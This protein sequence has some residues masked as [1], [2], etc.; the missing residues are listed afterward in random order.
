[1][2]RSSS[3]PRAS[4]SSRGGAAGEGVLLRTFHQGLQDVAVTRR[5]RVA[6]AARR[7]ERCGQGMLA[8]VGASEADGSAACNSL[9]ARAR[10]SGV[11]LS[12]LPWRDLERVLESDVCLM[13]Y[14]LGAPALWD[15]ELQRRL[16]HCLA[17]GGLATLTR[18]P[19]T[20]G[21]PTPDR[22]HLCGGG[23]LVSCGTVE[24]AASLAALLGCGQNRAKRSGMRLWLYNFADAESAAA[25]LAFHPAFGATEPGVRVVAAVSRT[26]RACRSV[27]GNEKG[28]EG[29]CGGGCWRVLVASHWVGSPPSSSPPLGVGLPQALVPT[30][31]EQLLERA[32]M[33]LAAAGL[34]KQDQAERKHNGES[35]EGEGGFGALLPELLEAFM[36]AASV[37]SDKPLSQLCDD[38]VVESLQKFL[39]DADC[40]AA[41][42]AVLQRLRGESDSLHRQGQSAGRAGR[43]SVSTAAVAANGHKAAGPARAFCRL[44]DLGFSAPAVKPGYHGSAAG[45]SNTDISTYG[46][47]RDAPSGGTFPSEEDDDGDVVEDEGNRQQLPQRV[48]MPANA[49]VTTS[50]R[51]VEPV[52]AAIR[53]ARSAVGSV[54]AYEEAWSCR[55][56]PVKAAE[57]Q[58]HPAVAAFIQRY[59]GPGELPSHRE[60]RAGA[61]YSGA[62]PAQPLQ[63]RVARVQRQEAPLEYATGALGRTSSSSSGVPRQAGLMDDC[64]FESLPPLTAR[65]SSYRWAMEMARGISAKALAFSGDEVPVQ[66][67]LSPDLKTLN[68]EVPG[69]ERDIDLCDVYQVLA[70][71]SARAALLGRL[72]GEAPANVCVFRLRGG[73]CL[74]LCLPEEQSPRQFSKRFA[75]V[76]GC[77]ASVDFDKERFTQPSAGGDRRDFVGTGPPSSSSWRVAASS[78]AESPGRSVPAAASYQPM[79]MTPAVQH[80]GCAAAPAPPVMTAWGSVG[81]SP[82]G[83]R[84]ARSLPPTPAPSSAMAASAAPVVMSPRPPVQCAVDA[85]PATVSAAAR[86]EYHPMCQSPAAPLDTRGRPGWRAR[87]RDAHAALASAAAGGVV[88]ATAVGRTAHAY[89]CSLRRAAADVC[90]PGACS[91]AATTESIAAAPAC[92]AKASTRC[93]TRHAGALPAAGISNGFPAHVTKSLA[94]AA[95]HHAGASVAG[96][97]CLQ[98]HGDAS[99]ALAAAAV[100]GRRLLRIRGLLCAAHQPRAL[101]EFLEPSVRPFSA[102]L[103]GGLSAVT[104]A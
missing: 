35:S 58:H 18:P 45:C 2:R 63:P 5:R 101:D 90:L 25:H 54:A 47:E 24:G 48:A 56:A 49:A 79:C 27:L 100:C 8:G 84:R 11:V 85:G 82:A 29:P 28:A 13:R 66:L 31:P 98:L 26:C 38:E 77:Q 44:E 92:A 23:M 36:E 71:E 17:S 80:M 42:D 53:D 14:Q 12:K 75:A 62:E 91:A 6:A 30:A 1:M 83:I 89:S 103:R 67:R 95:L 61:S 93:R 81:G 10:G 69:E 40:V 96:T 4:S 32:T 34:L 51:V 39:A 19:V 21:K 68:I 57:F 9:S 22:R 7:L 97:K 99:A 41:G 65:A 3:A 37:A 20:T 70:G 102:A 52:A 73:N 74:A 15:P 72:E 59:A 46:G 64:L 55:P 43:P 16:R 76:C 78:F 33:E 86:I 87:Q 104:T 50:Q 88:A 94:A 60:R